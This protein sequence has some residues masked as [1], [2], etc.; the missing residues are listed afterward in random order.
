MITIREQILQLL[1]TELKNVTLA[2]GYNTNIGSTVIRGR[3]DVA[4]EEVPA[5]V[6]IPDPE[7]SVHHSSH[8][9]NTMPVTLN[10]FVKFGTHNPSTEAEKILGDLITVMTSPTFT[11][12]FQNGSAQPSIG[13]T[14]TGVTSSATAIIK[15]ISTTSGSWAAGTAT[16]TFTIRL[17][18]SDFISETLQNA[19]GEYIAQST[20]TL[21]KIEPFSNMLNDIEYVSGEPDRLPSPGENIV[22]TSATFNITY[23]ILTGNPYQQ[24]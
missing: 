24:S 4:P 13:A 23:A 3:F 5:L 6:F 2:K 8:Q 21:T 17:M 19:V 9:I 11:L 15:S 16:G 18:H 14:I 20:G 10:G 7:T 22:K 12:A 1:D